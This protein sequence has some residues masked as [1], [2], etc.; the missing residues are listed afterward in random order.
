M[1][2]QDILNEIQSNQD[3][4]DN[5]RVLINNLKEDL[6]FAE[7]DLS[8]KNVQVERLTEENKLLKKQNA[9]LKQELLRYQK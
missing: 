1:S 8:A 5:A 3:K 6:R 7:A 9:D 4:L 2:K